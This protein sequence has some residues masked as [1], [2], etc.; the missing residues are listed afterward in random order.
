LK[1]VE[2]AVE[3]SKMLTQKC[4]Y[5][6]A[7]VDEGID[8]DI[9]QSGENF[10]VIDDEM[11]KNSLT[12]RRRIVAFPEGFQISNRVLSYSNESSSKSGKTFLF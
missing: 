2:N 6:S 7:E 4:N 5:Q 8:A 9:E 3:L 1:A 11:L 12:M 10:E